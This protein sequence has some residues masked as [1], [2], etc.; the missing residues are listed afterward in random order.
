MRSGTE[1]SMRKKKLRLQW[2]EQDT[3]IIPITARPD[4]TLRP[5][6]RRTPLHSTKPLTP[7]PRRSPLS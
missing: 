7:V 2:V 3:V 5:P 6:S 1:E 4:G